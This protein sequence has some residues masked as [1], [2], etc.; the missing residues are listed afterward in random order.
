MTAAHLGQHVGE[1]GVGFDTVELGRLNQ[2]SDDANE[3]VVGIM[4]AVTYAERKMISAR[5]KAALAE[6]K[7]RGVRLGKPEDLSNLEDG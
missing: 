1:V 6:A 4:A 2:G 3:F 7:A 5:T